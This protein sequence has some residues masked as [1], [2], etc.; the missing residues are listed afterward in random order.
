MARYTFPAFTTSTTPRYVVLWDMHWHVLDCQRLEA[1]ADLS[2]AMA[3]TIEHL[4]GEGWQAEGNAE[5]GFVFIRR[6]AE[7]WLLRLTERDPN[8]ATPQAFTPFR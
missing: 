8:E 7:R 6:K 5:C 2:G 3:A 4:S 1:A